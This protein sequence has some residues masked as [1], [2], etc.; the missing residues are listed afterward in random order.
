MLYYPVNSCFGFQ[1]SFN[2]FVRNVKKTSTVS[3]FLWRA[4]Y[5]PQCCIGIPNG[6]VVKASH[7]REGQ[8]FGSIL[9]YTIF[10]NLFKRKYLY[11]LKYI[12]PCPCITL[13]INHTGTYARTYMCTNHTHKWLEN[14]INRHIQ[15][16]V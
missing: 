15:I 11:T 12:T 4:V 5:I 16:Y 14:D 1:L 6:S 13:I 9:A 7:S 3:S 10:N 2:C 8:W